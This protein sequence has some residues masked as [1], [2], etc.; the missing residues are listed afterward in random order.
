MRFGSQPHALAP[1]C[2]TSFPYTTETA[3]V[4]SAAFV[5]L[6]LGSN[7]VNANTMGYT[8]LLVCACGRVGVCGGIWYYRWHVLR[9]MFTHTPAP[10][11]HKLHT[12]SRSMH[13]PPSRPR[14]GWSV[15]CHPTWPSSC[16]RLS[17]SQVKTDGGAFHEC[18]CWMLTMQ[19]STQEEKL[20]SVFQVG[21]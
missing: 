16:L 14:S 11:T 1:T 2:H 17:T 13:R 8:V 19:H 10:H 3:L 6:N 15:P 12:H 20:C 9:G 4:L 5:L 21:G 7:S 18:L